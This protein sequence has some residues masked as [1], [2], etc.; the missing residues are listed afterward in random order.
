MNKKDWIS[1]KIGILINEGRDRDQAAAIA[2]SMWDK[3]NYKQEGGSI[4]YNP[5]NEDYFKKVQEYLSNFTPALQPM[6]VQQMGGYYTNNSTGFQTNYGEPT[7][8]N[9]GEFNAPPNQNFNSISYNPSI[10]QNLNIPP[11]GMYLF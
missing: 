3:G 5:L 11:P 2:Y 1:N 4:V 9:N 8:P 10:P 6:P 7:V